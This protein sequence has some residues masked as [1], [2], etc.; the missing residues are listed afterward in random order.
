MSQQSST[1]T[2]P[3]KSVLLERVLFSMR[4]MWLALFAILTVY[5]GW[6]A[7]QVRPE[8][9]LTKM[10]PTNHEF[11]QNYFKHQE[12]LASLGNVIRV[13]VETTEGDIFT[14]EFQAT[15]QQITDEVFYV[16]GV[17]RSGLKSIWTPNVRWSEVTEEGFVGGPVIPD[18]WDASERSL[19]QL[20]TNI[21]R[22]GEVGN[23]VANNFKSA[24]I[25][26]PLYE[27]HP[28]TGEKLDYKV[29]S[30]ALEQNIRDKYQTDTVKIHITGFAKVIGDLIEGAYQVGLFF[31]IAIVITLVM[32][33][34]Y[35][36]CWRSAFAVLG[37]SIIAVVWQL[38]IIELIGSG[39]NPY[40]MLVP[41]LV[42]AI[43]VSHGVQ[44]I[45]AI[46]N[47]RVD[48]LDKVGATRL[49]FRGLYI[50]GLT[51]LV[52]DAIGFTTLMVIDIEVI[53]ELAIAASIGVAVVV[54]TNLGM[55]P[56]LMSYTGVSKDGVEYAAKA[57]QK[58]HPV[59]NIFSRFSRPKW[60]YSA[61]VVALMGLAWG[62]YY[63]QQMKIGDLDA[64]APELRPDSRY[65]LDNQFIV[66]NYSS[67][68]DVFV[69]MAET[70]P[71]QCIAYDNLELLDRFTWH[72]Q[73]TPGV[74]DVKS[75]A[76]V[77]KMGSYGLNEGNLKWYSLTRNQYSLN[78]YT[79]RTP[80]GL[81]N[82]DCSMA[83][84]IIFLN[85]HKAETLQTVV[86]SV[87]S[88]N[89]EYQQD[90]LELL[91][92]AG[93]SGIEA[94]TNSVIESAQNK[95]MLWV[96]GVVIF[97]CLL[98]FRSLRTVTCIILPLAL[99]TVMSQ[100]L[101][102]VLGIGVKVATLPVIALGVG[103]GVDYGI[104]IYTKIREGLAQGMHLDDSYKYALDS[105]G[106]A[107]G[108]T[109]LTL[110]I[111]VATWIFSPI[112]FQAD[113]GILLTFM[114]IWNMLGALILIPALARFFANFSRKAH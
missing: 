24:L 108:F 78:G 41:F 4:P 64:G 53:Q 5:L 86:A 94:A 28:D 34:W 43:G 76:Y 35:S 20:R 79:G 23:L 110:A 44:I 22:S 31:V 62:L 12:D 68:T 58:E 32:L 63:G 16:P 107:V 97:L 87:N 30:E 73:N 70:A 84:V 18:T 14:P 98:T 11:I 61:L 109:G 100:G 52:S 80:P 83:P 77:A 93:N 69:V 72:M 29:L 105:T 15:L 33:Y 39:I 56:I 25:Y 38:G 96:Y 114:F 54:L 36:R 46:S 59:L 112:K 7:S 51:A 88:F 49:A 99:T 42:F 104:Y 27:V 1:S 6:H 2:P 10:I 95:M 91:M 26:V 50:A 21:L 9:S 19:D 102:A 82:P 89:Q 8:A 65:N 74:Q 37:C 57:R 71:S 90:G 17:D 85:D 106:K 103:I 101:M 111:G 60:A 13:A 113:M 3:G 47:N 81:I 75:V 40:S 66:D 48:A 92:A 45:N 67:S 55:L